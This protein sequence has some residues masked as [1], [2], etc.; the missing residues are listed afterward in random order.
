M[1]EPHSE[2]RADADE[3]S[4]APDFDVLTP[5]DDLVRGNRT[6]DDFFDAVLGLDTPATASE[7][8]EL[9]GHGVDA[10]R[11]YLA[12]FERMGIVTQPTESPA[13]YQRNQEY[14]NWRRVQG[15]RE[16]HTTEELLNFLKGESERI[17]EFK[18]EFNANSPEEVSITSYAD[19]ADQSIE[20]V[21]RRLSTWQTAHRRVRLLERALS[22]ESG[23]AAD[24]KPAV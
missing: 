16:E 17:D 13:T 7:V 3:R 12:W 9:A 6:R 20:E 4:D 5:P 11:E 1:K 19:A 8:A 21:W 10:A 23:D 14:L 24:L 22:T 18:D 2:L 15:L